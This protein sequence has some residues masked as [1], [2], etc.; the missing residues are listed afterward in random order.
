MANPPAEKRPGSLDVCVFCGAR[1]GNSTAVVAAAREL[2]TL[3]GEAGHRLVYGG[4]GVGLMGEVAWAAYRGGARVTGIMPRFL[5]AAED[6]D[7]APPQDLRLTATL[8]ERKERML[9]EADCFLALPGG[10]GTL[11]EV[12]EVLT[13]MKLRQQHKPLVLVQ[14]DQAWTSFLEVAA[15]IGRRGFADPSAGDLIKVV[16]SPAE[17]VRLI[18]AEAR[19]PHVPARTARPAWKAPVRPAPPVA[20]SA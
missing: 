1:L 4:G 20:R 2:G 14:V 7:V 13:L 19:R 9:R 18:G 16:D 3:L 17:A 15:E 10:F 11:D 8:A 12:L 6:A 5:Y